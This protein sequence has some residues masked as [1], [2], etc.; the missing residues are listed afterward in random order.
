MKR[1]LEQIQALAADVTKTAKVRKRLLTIA[2]VF[3]VF[4]L[5]FVRELIAAELLFGLGFAVLLVVVGIFY[6]VGAIGERIIDATQTR[7]H[8]VADSARR[9]YS[10]AS[11]ALNAVAKR[12]I[13]LTEAEAK[14]IACSVRRA[15]TTRP[16][17]SLTRPLPSAP[18]GPR[19]AAE[20][21]SPEQL[22]L[23]CQDNA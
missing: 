9:G 10:V 15:N 3:I 22:G 23:R 20:I 12:G 17:N 8:V 16:R 4:Q 19:P 11:P 1:I 2:A 18:I 14:V 7:A 21:Q 6:V 13:D 5:Y